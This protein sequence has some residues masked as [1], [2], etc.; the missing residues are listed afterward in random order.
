MTYEEARETKDR[1]VEKLFTPAMTDEDMAL[2]NKANAVIRE[3][4]AALKSTA[5][6]EG[7]APQGDPASDAG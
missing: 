1:L 6:K 2:L 4:K 5:A 7:D 3:H